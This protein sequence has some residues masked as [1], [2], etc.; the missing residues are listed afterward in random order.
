MPAHKHVAS[1][2]ARALDARR[3]SQKPSQADAKRPASGQ[4]DLLRLAAY[5][6]C[7]SSAAVYSAPKSA[8]VSIVGSI[9]RNAVYMM[10]SR[11][12]PEKLPGSAFSVLPGVN[13]PELTIVVAERSR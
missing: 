11:C 4:M 13:Y 7:R 12:R 3:S 5:C 2:S 1:A 9:C 6:F 10:A 8:P